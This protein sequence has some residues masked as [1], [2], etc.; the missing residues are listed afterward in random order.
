M[1]F[2]RYEDILAWGIGKCKDFLSG[3]VGFSGGYW[4]EYREGDIGNAGCVEGE[5]GDFIRF[6]R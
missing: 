1:K 5:N 6:L 3:E 2:L 4:C